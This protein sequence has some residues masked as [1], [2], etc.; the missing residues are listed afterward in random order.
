MSSRI[1]CALAAT[2]CAIVLAACA[3]STTSTR[4]QSENARSVC[5]KTQFPVHASDAQLTIYKIAGELC[6]RGRGAKTVLVTSHGASYNHL[7]FR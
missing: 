5:T 4:E 6:K 1:H 2:V 3:V 7:Y